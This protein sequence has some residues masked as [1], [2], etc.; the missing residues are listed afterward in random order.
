MLRTGLLAGCAALSA[1]LAA[2]AT[3]EPDTH[4]ADIQ[5]LKD[6]E[7]AWVS[8]A[9]SKDVE[10]FVAHYT[11]DAS[12]LI[13]NAPILTGK[14]AIRNALKPMLADPNFALTF[15]AAKADVA[16]SGDLGYMQGPYTMTTTD[17]KTK[18][19]AVEKGK[20][21]TVFH[22]QAD[23]TWKAVEDTFMADA[24]PATAK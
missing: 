24:P 4:D 2:C 1:L 15:A 8:D 17:A 18:A 22:K 7:A 9:A 3:P 21:L 5:A 16:K 14:A 20:Y 11:D 12:V 13:P 10:K 23:G 6:T 19:P